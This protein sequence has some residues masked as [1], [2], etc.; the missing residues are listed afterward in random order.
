MQ[1]FFQICVGFFAFG[2][3]RLFVRPKNSI[4]EGV[5]IPQQPLGLL[6][7]RMCKGE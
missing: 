2:S 6:A 5:S 4:I 1:V 3:K 7:D